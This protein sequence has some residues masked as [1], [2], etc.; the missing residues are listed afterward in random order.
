MFAV[1]VLSKTNAILRKAKFHAER[2][3]LPN[4]KAFFIVTAEKLR[5][6]IPYTKLSESLGILKKDVILNSNI[7]LPDNCGITLF[8]PDIFPRILLINSAVAFLRNRH[9][10]S[11]ILFDEEAIYTD[12]IQLLVKSFERIRVITPTPKAYDPAARK[13]MEDFGFSLEVSSENS[14]QGDVIISHKCCV[15]LYYSGT[16]FT[17]KKQYL[18]N[19]K[20]FSGSSV[21]L[22]CPYDKFKPQNTDTVLFASALYEKCNVTELK[23]LQYSDFGC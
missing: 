11:L 17:N 13:L 16:V 19:A 18:M 4:D 12:Y 1:L 23:D 14:F 3:T 20:V 22:P 7:A 2:I 6:K 5:G 21:T 15:P 10:E 9:Y 8:I